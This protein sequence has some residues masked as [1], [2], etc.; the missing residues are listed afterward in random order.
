MSTSEPENIPGERLDESGEEKKVIPLIR[1]GGKHW[2]P[3][4][5]AWGD[6]KRGA[7]EM[8]GIPETRASSQRQT[9]RSHRDIVNVWNVHA[10]YALYDRHELVY[11]GEGLLGERLWEHRLNDSLRHRWDS[12][13]WLSPA[14]YVDPVEGREDARTDPG[15]DASRVVGST[16]Q[17]VRLLEF[18][19]IQLADPSENRKV[20]WREGEVRWLLQ[21]PAEEAKPGTERRLSDLDLKLEKILVELKALRERGMNPVTP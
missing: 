19:G 18:V 11:V 12:F 16:K 6:G 15:S 13:T 7:Y 17:L 3:E 10:V 9:P 1:L 4:L 21:R 8:L 2:R 5:V 14:T 20:P